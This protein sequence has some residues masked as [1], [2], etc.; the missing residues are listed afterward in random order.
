M[1]AQSAQQTLKSVGESITSYNGLVKAYY[2]K[3]VDK[4]SLPKYRKRSGLA[5]V[6]FPKQALTWKNGCFY[7]SVSNETKPH[8]FFCGGVAPA[9]MHGG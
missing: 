4:P 7:P 3:E 8:R 1:A 2:R 6:S 9:F 5:A